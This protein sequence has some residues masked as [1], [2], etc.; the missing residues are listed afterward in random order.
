MNIGAK[1]KGGKRAP[2]KMNSGLGC[3]ASGFSLIFSL[4]SLI[5]CVLLYWKTSGLL[6]RVTALEES[7]SRTWELSDTPLSLQE[8]ALHA[9][10]QPQIHHILQETLGDKIA[11]L[12]TVREAPTDC[13]CPP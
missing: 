1:E 12:R 4:T 3:W 6:S 5:A 13:V 8:G 10:L 11:K 2:W 7:G 9:I